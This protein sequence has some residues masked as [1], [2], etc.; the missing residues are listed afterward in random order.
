VILCI[1]SG[2]SRIKWG[3]HD[4][5]RWLEVGFVAHADVDRLTSLAR[6]LPQETRVILA[7]VAGDAALAS[8]RQALTPCR[9]ALHEVK[10]ASDAGGVVNLYQVPGRL[11]VDRWSALIGARGLTSAPCLVLMAGTATTI[12][13]LDGDGRFLGGLILPG[14]DL[15]RRSL[16]RDTAALPLAAGAYS[17]YPR[18]TD[19]AII[20]GCIEAQ[21]G[22]IE[23]AFARL[24]N[25]ATCLLSGGAARVI[26][27]HLEIPHRR[28]DNLVLE[29]LL[30]LARDLPAWHAGGQI[31]S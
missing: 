16:A 18:G 28:V 4:A 15:M 25:G 17:A 19:D 13:T 10:S 6:R 12:D 21:I 31:S 11:G 24:G 1:D 2:N 30:R 3:V 8:I 14:L 29:G 20:S 7:N 26:G 23:R 22:A 27:E 9:P 5:G